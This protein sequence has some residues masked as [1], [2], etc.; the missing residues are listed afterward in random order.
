MTDYFNSI[1]ASLKEAKESIDR[2]NRRLSILRLI[3]FMLAAAF[4]IAGIIKDR[5]VLL[6]CAAFA[7]LAV[8]V[9]LCIVHGRSKEMAELLMQKIHAND[10]YTA[11]IKGDYSLLEDE[12]K[13]FADNSHPYSSDL[14]LFG[15]HS[16]FSLYNISHSVFGRSAF[17][18]KLK[19]KD[20]GNLDKKGIIS[21]QNAVAELSRDPEFLLDYE[22]VGA[23]HPIDKL[24]EALMRLCAKE[25][26]LPKGFKL[27][28][29][30]A[31]FLWIIPV[32]CVVLSAGVYVR[33]SVLAVILVNLIIWFLS[34]RHDFADIFKAGK[35]SGQA[36]AIKA[37]VDM[38]TDETKK[39]IFVPGYIADDF[40]SEVRSL[41]K[42]CNLCSLRD[43]PISALI[44]NVLIP[45]DLI[46][47]D[48][49]LDWS[50]DHGQSFI[51]NV[52]G[53][54]E[55]EA[56]MCATV[57]GL[58]HKES[59]VPEIEDEKTAYFSG[60]DMIHP[61]LQPQ[62]A[63]ANSVCID[64][65]SALITGSN[66]SGK[67]TLIRTVGIMCVL[68]YTGASVPAKA[69]RTSIM[70]IMTSMRIA[71]SLEEN[72]STFRAELIRIGS[73]VEASATE[74]PLLYLIDEVFRG[75]NSQDRTDGAEILLTKLDKP[76]IAGFMTTHDYALCDRIA[77][78]RLK[79]GAVFFHFSERYEG[80]EV[81]FDYKLR[82]GMSHESNA[83]FLMRLVGIE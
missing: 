72:M 35:I 12:G 75:T 9:F 39:Q 20:F 25:N 73:I 7:F 81:I 16:I 67:T 14:D 51:R 57:P 58:V 78:G 76:Y 61:L 18:D 15:S 31:P 10:R 37:R 45:F 48:R 62:K 60:T 80:D 40:E 68:A 36:A 56:L 46:C 41:I 64:S 30:T 63:V 83:R 77:D 42:A 50:L 11:R 55:A 1:A 4:V 38:L 44:L 52:K 13:E 65:K 59:C 24:P 21:L 71:D 27:L 53:L 19:G 2:V 34:S 17:A 32:L 26:R 82:E 6:F 33:I 74:I 70:R 79:D 3:F 43:Q 66:M 5:N 23:A 54:G 8:F 49:L 29:K 22:A 47:A 28:Y 69:V